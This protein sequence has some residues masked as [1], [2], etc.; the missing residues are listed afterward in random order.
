MVE[1]G[2][3][4]VRVELSGFRVLG[5]EDTECIGVMVIAVCVYIR[6]SVEYVD[7]R[8]SFACDVVEYGVSRAVTIIFRDLRFTF[9]EENEGRESAHMKALTESVVGC[10]IDFS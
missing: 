7:W 4:E 8:C 6:G 1:V 3:S 10:Y 2:G 5:G 9:D